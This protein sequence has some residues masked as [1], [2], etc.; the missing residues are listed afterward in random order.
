M[1]FSEKDL[2]NGNLYYKNLLMSNGLGGYTSMGVY[3]NS[4]RK[5]DGYL[6]GSLTAPTNRFVFLQRTNEYIDGVNL[7]SSETL[8]EKNAGYEFMTG[9]SFSVDPT[10][11]Y[12]V[13]GTEMKKKVCP[14][15]GKNA[16][17]INYDFLSKNKSNIDIVFE[18]CNRFS[19]NVNE[20]KDFNLTVVKEK[21][22][23]IVEYPSIK[24]KVYLYL[25]EDL[26]INVL[27]N[28]F[29]EELKFDY[30]DRMGDSRTSF[31][32]KVL[33]ANINLNKREHHNLS[34]IASLT[35]II[36]LEESF[37]CNNYENIINDVI[38][39]SELHEPFLESLTKS[40]FQFIS[41]RESTSNL[42][43]LAGYPWF[44]D[45]GRDTMISLP[46]ICLKTKRYEDALSILNSFKSY[47]KDGLIPN[48]FLGEDNKPLY[49]SVDAPLWYINCVYKYA[50][51]ANDYEGIRDLYPVCMDIIKNYKNGTIFSI[52][53]NSNG[54]IH[55]GS[56]L[57]QI[58]WMDVRINGECVTPRHGY[59]VEINALWYNA[60][61]CMNKMQN[62]FMDRTD[63][64][65]VANKVKESFK[66]FIK[67]DGGLYDV[68]DPNDDSVRPNQ[69]YAY[70]L[71]FKVLDKEA[72]KA[73][74]K[75]VKNELFNKYGLRSLS[76]N[77]PRFISEYSGSIEKRDHS[78]HMGTSW[79][80][81]IGVYVDAL[82]YLNDYDYESKKEAKLILTGFKNLM[83]DMC[84]DGIP[85]IYDGNDTYESKGCYN[86][87][88]GVAEVLRAYVENL[89]EK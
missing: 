7:D 44:T 29:T 54:L 82:C 33:S 12:E 35:P 74:F 66:A 6:V 19:E 85:E 39:K 87:A 73:S 5:Q 72:A 25:S 13:N 15:Y 76:I 23:Y 64:N 57:D 11:H 4:F 28:E 63:Y 61:M 84:L 67:P 31:S 42:T 78:Y 27:T 75:I 81:L 52:Y 46:G 58:T 68:L 77:D 45:W 86:Q 49:N 69:L 53:M 62:K 37:K 43:I 10:F 70:T 21:D 30:D 8:K 65:T 40:A 9:F 60:L 26:N 83:K 14:I 32:K 1:N 36:D 47:L 88:W 18:F 3:N 89:I 22:Y 80:F 17:L 34:I 20:I 79:T 59:P 24:E 2:I 71:P 48:A 51:E 56:E 41:K 16:C 38:I 55:A 50:V